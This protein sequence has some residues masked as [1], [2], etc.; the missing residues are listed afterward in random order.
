MFSF[1]NKDLP[2]KRE[3]RSSLQFLNGVGWRKAVLI[4]SKVGL[5]YPFFINNLNFYQFGLISFLLKYLVLSA[6]RV[7]R[8][9][10]LRIKTL[11]KLLGHRGV[12][13]RD[14]LPVRGQRTRS[15]AGVRKSLIY[16]GK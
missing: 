4:S 11:V 10:S 16:G 13:H 2:L 7:N 1:R 15:N 8:V 6:V 5:A 12:R 14:S 9:I 3:I